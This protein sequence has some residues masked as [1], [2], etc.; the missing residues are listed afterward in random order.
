MKQVQLSNRLLAA[1][2]MVTKGNIVADIGCDHAYT[3]IYLCQAGI[4]PKVIAMDVNKG[5]LVGAR[6]H[7]EEAGLASQITIRLSDGLQKLAPGEADTVLLCG[8]GGLL[9]I[10]ILSDFPEATASL[11]E[12]VLQPQSEVGEV[13]MFLHKQ[14]Y[15][16]TKEHM[17]KEDGRF[18]VMMRAVKS[19]APQAYETECDYL[20]GKLLI[21]EKHEVLLEYLEREQRLRTDVLAALS[22]QD[23]ENARLRKESLNRE[24]SLIEEARTRIMRK[25]DAE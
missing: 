3:S 22:G 11:K 8:M 18:Y 10:K 4:A 16:I 23:T 20:Y 5:P 1:A 12:L 6:A 14:G 9:M 17:L 24:F 19:T 15:E 25:V 13:R 2:G 7:V 21:E